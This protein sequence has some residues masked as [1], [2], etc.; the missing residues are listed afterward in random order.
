MSSKA[1]I[2]FVILV[3]DFFSGKSIPLL[4]ALA[5][6][7]LHSGIIAPMLIL[8]AASGVS[9]CTFATSATRSSLP[10]LAA[11][12]R[13]AHLSFAAY[14]S[15]S[16]TFSIADAVCPDLGVVL[17]WAPAFTV[18]SAP[19]LQRQSTT[20]VALVLGVI[21]F[22][23]CAFSS[24]P[25]PPPLSDVRP[26]GPLM[27]YAAPPR[28]RSTRALL[29]IQ[30]TSTLAVVAR[31]LQ[32]YLLAFYAN[33]HHG[34]LQGIVKD[35]DPEYG[36][37]HLTA[38]PFYG[39]VVRSFAALIRTCLWIAVGFLH[40]NQLHVMLDNTRGAWGW[41]GCFVMSLNLLFNAIYTLR[42]AVQQTLPLT[43]KTTN[44]NEI[45]RK[46]IAIIVTLAAA[47]RQRD[48]QSTFLT[49]ASLSTITVVS[50]VYHITDKP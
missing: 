5:T 31:A 42:Q 1:P 39:L 46:Y 36:S 20:I 44:V 10:Q 33:V 23:V 13:L 8:G 50:A 40:D 27:V 48:F 43:L 9:F 6:F 24:P 14:C 11:T 32:L 29:T 49:A 2:D 15:L 45:S 21:A 37:Y 16:L 19:L 28:L 22:Y 35:G 17:S 34:Q 25:A 38:S 7:P 4:V 47:H 18:C 26:Q 12:I 3:N 30:E 41:P